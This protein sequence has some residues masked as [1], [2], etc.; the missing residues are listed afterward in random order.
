MAEIPEAEYRY[1]VRVANTDLDGRKPIGHALRRITGVGSM[2]A[3]AVCAVSGVDPY[4]QTGK[5]S[6]SEIREIDAVLSNPLQHSIP[7]WLFNRRRDPESGEAKHLLTSELKFQRENDIKLMK[8]IKTY[9]GM[10][11]SKGLPVRGQRTRSNFRKNKGKVSLGVKKG[12]AK[13]A[14][15]AAAS[16]KK[17]KK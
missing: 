6:D 10:R 11:H 16:E 5:L 7:A 15:A 9:K 3:H 8:R 4:A 13:A 2:F 17:E 12:A 1:L 14:A